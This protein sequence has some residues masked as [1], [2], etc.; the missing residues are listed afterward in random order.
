[1]LRILQLIEEMRAAQGRTGVDKSAT[2]HVPSELVPDA[3]WQG[4]PWATGVRPSCEASTGFAPGNN[5]AT[6]SA[7]SSADAIGAS[8]H[9]ERQRAEKPANAC[10]ACRSTEFWLRPDGERICNRCHPK[11]RRR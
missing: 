1:M 11:P 4:I 8:E 9:T 5:C 7:D 6:R 2:K 10:F 3:E